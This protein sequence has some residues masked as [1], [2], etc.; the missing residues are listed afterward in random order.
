MQ[1][2]R[3]P[4]CLPILIVDYRKFPLILPGERQGQVGVDVPPSRIA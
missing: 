2:Y 4:N 3:S 1:Q